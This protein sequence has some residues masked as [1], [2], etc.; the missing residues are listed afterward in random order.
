MTIIRGTTPTIKYTFSVIAGT[1][2]T[3]AVMT[4]SQNGTVLIEKD[5]SA[6]V[7]DETSVSW[8]LSQED[9]LKLDTDFAARITLNWKLADGTRGASKI[10]IASVEENDVSEVI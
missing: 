1:D 5:L 6:G 10:A 3:V 7:A 4:V 2:L 9:T 8:V